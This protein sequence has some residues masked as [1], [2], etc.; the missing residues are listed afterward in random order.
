MTPLLLLAEN[1]PG[2]S[3]HATGGSAPLPARDTG[4]PNEKSGPEGPL[5]FLLPEVD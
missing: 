2:E 1:I 5:F 3:R 4:D